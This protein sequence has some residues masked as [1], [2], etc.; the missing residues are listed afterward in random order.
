MFKKKENAYKDTKIKFKTPQDAIGVE[1]DKTSTFSR[2]VGV[3]DVIN[4]N[5]E[6]I[7]VLI[8]ETTLKETGQKKVYSTCLPLR[9]G[10]IRSTKK[11]FP[12]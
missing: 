9:I 3:E 1:I 11:A 6:T 8:W 7:T 5:G 2:C 12:A 4:K 10:D